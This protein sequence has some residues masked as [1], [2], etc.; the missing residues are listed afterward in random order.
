MMGVRL[1]KILH[2]VQDDII[3]DF[4]ILGGAKNLSM[5]LLLT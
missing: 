3:C 4:V 2:F 1:K 5:A